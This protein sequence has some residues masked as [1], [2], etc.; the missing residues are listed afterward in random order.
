MGSISYSVCHGKP[1]QHILMQHLS[2]LGSFKNYTENEL[3]WIPTLISV[4]DLPKLHCCRVFSDV[5]PLILFHNSFY[6]VIQIEMWVIFPGF[7][8]SFP[9]YKTILNFEFSVKISTL[10]TGEW[11]RPRSLMLISLCYK[12]F[13]DR[14]IQSLVKKQ[15]FLSLASLSSLV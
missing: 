3:L 2:L 5:L 15:E 8:K 7:P 13:Y 6:Y 11:L 10:D 14:N 12:T 1:F 9:L 4:Y